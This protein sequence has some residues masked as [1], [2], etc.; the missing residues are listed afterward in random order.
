[1]AGN[2]FVYQFT[3]VT[4]KKNLCNLKRETAARIGGL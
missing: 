2:N 4:T 1:M 3:L